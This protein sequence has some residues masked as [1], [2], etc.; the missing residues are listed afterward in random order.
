MMRKVGIACVLIGL[1]FLATF[2]NNTVVYYSNLNARM[3]YVDEL[4]NKYGFEPE[5]RMY[6]KACYMFYCPS[7]WISSF[8][9]TTPTEADLLAKA[10]LF[11]K[12]LLMEKKLAEVITVYHKAMEAMLNRMEQYEQLLAEYK[13]KLYELELRVNE[14]EATLTLF[15]EA[16][17]KEFEEVY[18][19]IGTLYN[20]TSDLYNRTAQLNATIGNLSSRVAKLEKQVSGILND[21]CIKDLNK[22]Y[23]LVQTLNKTVQTFKNNVIKPILRPV[24]DF[25]AKIKQSLWHWD[26]MAPIWWWESL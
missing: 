21:P 4:C 2:L 12:L 26:W 6:L 5:T 19:H 1:L 14:C 23:S 9:L 7:D 18:T 11:N 24:V 16:I 13:L 22:F 20:Y 25:I 3:S 17:K 8:F 10:V 15:A